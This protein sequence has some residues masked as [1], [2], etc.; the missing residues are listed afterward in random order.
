MIDWTKVAFGLDVAE[1]ILKIVAYIVGA[2]WV[3]FN[4]FKGR[5]YRPRLETR[6]SGQ[7]CR[8]GSPELVQVTFEVKNVGLSKVDV[9]QTGTAMRLLAYDPDTAGGWRHLQTLDI[10]VRHGWIEPGE[11]VIEQALHAVEL[12]KICAVKVEIVITGETTM[13]EASAILV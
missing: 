11:V 7:L 9:A 4:F 6:V 8:R 2:G 3:Y 5:T 1:K 12:T 10:L 13:W